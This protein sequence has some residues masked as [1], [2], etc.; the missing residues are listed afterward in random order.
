MNTIKKLMRRL[1]NG[2]KGQVDEWV[3]TAHVVW[4]VVIALCGFSDGSCD[5]GKCGAGIMIMACSKALGWFPIYKKCWPVVGQSS[6]D[7]EL[8]VCAMLTEFLRQ[9]MDKCVR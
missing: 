2:S 3:D 5:N 4:S 1:G 8:G 7:A 9:W 6:L